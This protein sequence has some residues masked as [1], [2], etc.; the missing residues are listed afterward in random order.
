MDS[1]FRW[2]CTLYTIVHRMYNTKAGIKEYL[3]G[4]F[5]VIGKGRRWDPKTPFMRPDLW[6]PAFPFFS[7]WAIIRKKLP[8]ILSLINSLW[9]WLNM[10]PL[11]SEKDILSIEK[12]IGLISL[13]ID[14][15]WFLLLI[16]ICFLGFHWST[17]LSRKGSL[18][19]IM[20]L[21]KKAYKFAF[22]IVCFPN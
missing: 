2:K 3:R 17:I 22:Y 13:W 19:S 5:N 10:D 12:L 18:N 8:E 9:C 16:L 11:V 21:F 4:L 6:F 15:Y 1:D 14:V 7:L 20:Y